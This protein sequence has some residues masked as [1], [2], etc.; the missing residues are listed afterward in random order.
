MSER[1]PTHLDFSFTQMADHLQIEPRTLRAWNR[2][3][4][5]VLDA[6]IDDDEPRYS[7]HDLAALDHCPA[8]A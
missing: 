6:D 4:A 8:P 2:H 7:G 1:R 3:L 5:P